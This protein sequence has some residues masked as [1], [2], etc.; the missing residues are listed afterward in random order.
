[1]LENLRYFLYQFTTTISSYLGHRFKIDQ[2]PEG[3]MAGG[4]YILSKTALKKFIEELLPSDLPQC[5][6]YDDA[7]EDFRMGK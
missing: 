5:H 1:M 7:A 3:Y 4:G 6:R 2:L